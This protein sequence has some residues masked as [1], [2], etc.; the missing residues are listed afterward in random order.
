MKLPVAVIDIG[1]KQT[2]LRQIR[3]QHGIGD[4]VKI[5]FEILPYHAA[6]TG[7]RGLQGLAARGQG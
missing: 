3:Q 1:A 2:G 7:H 4:D 6:N 5:G